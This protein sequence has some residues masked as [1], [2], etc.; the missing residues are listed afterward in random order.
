MVR[1]TTIFSLF[2]LVI[3]LQSRL[4]I[5]DYYFVAERFILVALSVLQIIVNYILIDF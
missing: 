3:S 2:A 1:V 5:I 4:Y